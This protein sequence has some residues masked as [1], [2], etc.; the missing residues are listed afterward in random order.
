V[1]ITILGGGISGVSLAYFLLNK[2]NIDTL[3]VHLFEKDESIGGLCQTLEFNGF[4]SDFGPHN[5][6][7]TDKY[8]NKLMKN[9]FGELYRARLYKAQVAFMGKFVPYPMEGTDILKCV[10]LLTSISCAISFLW[11]R[12]LSVFRKW[13]DSNFMKYIINRFGPKLYSIYFGPFT[14]K[15][16]GVSGAVLSADFAKDRIGTF[17]LWDLFKRT[18]LGIKPRSMDTDEDAFLNTNADYHDEGSQPIIDG[19]L[20]H[21]LNDSRFVLHRS[22]PITSLAF[23]QNKISTVIS[24]DIHLETDFVFSSIS[25]TDLASMT[26]FS[27]ELKFTSTR[28]LFMTIDK[29]TVFGDTPWI[30]FSD[31]STLFNRVYE[32][33]NMSALMS[34]EGKTSL[35]FE[36]TSNQDDPIWAM[37]D[38]DLLEA[39]IS[40]LS[41]YELLSEND[42]VDWKVI[43][44]NNTYPL[45]LVD[46]QQ[47]KRKV[48]KHLDKFEN[49]VSYGR[50]GGFEYFNMDH[51]VMR[52]S[53]I[54]AQFSK[55]V[56]S[57]LGV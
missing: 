23:S 26:G 9:M 21:C 57:V 47:E 40:G 17:N 43:D 14:R 1:K 55:V 35:C 52:A 53:E 2:L 30:Y 46:Y 39:A 20:N 15:T 27:S 54:A 13:D 12:F 29:S 4:K 56:N 28:F 36:F 38:E 44:W 19:F 32:P 45:R 6:H 11:S 7:S 41:S 22:S 8:F 25:V 48:F 24:N 49:L 50:L 33:K 34:P 37:K 10:P 31:E 5:I 18:F 3:Q 51:C 16:W 42:I